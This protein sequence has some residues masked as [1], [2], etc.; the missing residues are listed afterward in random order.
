MSEFE[1]NMH[2][3]G[4]RIVGERNGCKI[5]ARMTVEVEVE[6]EK[7]KKTELIKLN[8]SNMLFSPGYDFLYEN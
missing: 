3:M 5:W 1:K 7:I 8:R 2:E 4:F 6:V